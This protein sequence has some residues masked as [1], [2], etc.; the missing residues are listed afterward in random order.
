MRSPRIELKQTPCLR[1]SERP[2]R[3]SGAVD[4]AVPLLGRKHDRLAQLGASAVRAPMPWSN[5][6]LLSSAV[7]RRTAPH[8]SPPAVRIVDSAVRGTPSRFGQAGAVL[9]QWIVLSGP[10]WARDRWA[11]APLLELRFHRSV[12]GDGYAQLGGEF[13]KAG[14]AVDH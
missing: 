12:R 3:V 9:V 2:K 4:G 10:G 14:D 5:L 11:T 1:H 7:P 8:L 6:S 13:S